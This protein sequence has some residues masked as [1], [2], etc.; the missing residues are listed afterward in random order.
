LES[1]AANVVDLRFLTNAPNPSDTSH[2]S[3]TT[4]TVQF[5]DLVSDNNWA[6]DRKTYTQKEK[7]TNTNP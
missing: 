6:T 3:H 7:K 2:S 5:S 4:A 1:T